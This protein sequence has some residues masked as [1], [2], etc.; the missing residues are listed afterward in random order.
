MAAGTLPTPIISHFSFV[1]SF[2]WLNKDT[3]KTDASAGAGWTK[4]DDSGESV[5]HESGRRIVEILRRNPSRNPGASPS[6]IPPPAPDRPG[7]ANIYLSVSG[8]TG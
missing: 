6:L 5:G 1:R 8:L 3:K 2:G 4:D 7:P